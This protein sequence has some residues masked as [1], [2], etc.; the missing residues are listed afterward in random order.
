M[1]FRFATGT[2]VRCI[3]SCR[4][5]PEKLMNLLQSEFMS[6]KTNLTYDGKKGTYHQFTR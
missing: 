6:Y 1:R 3:K 5:N 2:F 4:G